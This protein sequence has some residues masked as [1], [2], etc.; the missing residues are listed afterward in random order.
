MSG[1]LRTGEPGD[2]RK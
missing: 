2:E 1:T